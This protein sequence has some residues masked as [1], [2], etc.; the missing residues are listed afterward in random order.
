MTQNMNTERNIWKKRSIFFD[1]PYWHSHDVRH[2][3]YVMH[4]EKNVCDSVISILLHICVQSKDGI[5]ARLD[6][7]KMG[8]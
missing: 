2:S 5:N 1:L 4:V 7:A 3:I 8:T 6:L